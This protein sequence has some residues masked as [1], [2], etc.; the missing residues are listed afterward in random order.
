MSIAK[1]PWIRIQ[2]LD[3]CEIDRL[4]NAW[5]ELKQYP[6]FFLGRWD[7]R[8]DV[9]FNSLLLETDY[10]ID[11]KDRDCFIALDDLLDEA[12]SPSNTADLSYYEDL[13]AVLRHWAEQ[14]DAAIYAWKHCTVERWNSLDDAELRDLYVHRN[15]ERDQN[16]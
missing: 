12:T 1:A 9:T 6:H 7:G 2:E 5:T 15:A 4:E 10:G 8:F 3:D 16:K 11:H 14:C 13:A